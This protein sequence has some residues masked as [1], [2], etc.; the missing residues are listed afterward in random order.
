MIKGKNAIVTGVSKGIGLATA[1]ALLEKGVKVAGWSRT[2]PDLIHENFQFIEVDVA[3][4]EQVKE[5]HEKTIALM[6][7][8]IHILI[9]NAG[10]GVLGAIDEISVK[11]WKA[12]FDVNVHG[13]MYCTKMVVPQMKKMDQ[14]HIVNISSIAGLNPVKNMSGYAATKHAVTG[15][16]HSLFMELRDWGI[17]VTNIYPGSV[18]T[19]FFDE[20]DQIEANDNMMRPQDVAQSIVGVLDTHPNFLTVDVELRPLRPKGK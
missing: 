11:D 6:G 20:I 10:F 13:L 16:G 3:D 4:F 9:N 2:A 19:Q 5:A 1:K 17:K 18:S 7:A 15:I 14:G 8:E 12:M